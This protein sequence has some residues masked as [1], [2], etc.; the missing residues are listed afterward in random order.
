M[1][2][3]Y[4][5]GGTTSYIRVPSSLLWLSLLIILCC[6]SYTVATDHYNRHTFPTPLN[7]LATSELLSAISHAR[8]YSLNML[9][10]RNISLL[11]RLYIWGLSVI[12]RIAYGPEHRPPREYEHPDAQRI[13][14]INSELEFGPHVWQN[15]FLE[16]SGYVS[17][18]HRQNAF[19]LDDVATFISDGIEAI[20]DDTLT[21]CFTA[22]PPH[23]WN[24]LTRNI[25]PGRWHMTPYNSLLWVVGIWARYFVF[26]PMR[27]VIVILGVFLF[28]VAWGM[29]CAIPSLPIKRHV[30]KWL[31]RFLA[32]VVAASWSGYI[33][34]H[35]KRPERR[36]H[37][38][39][40][41]N[42][43]SLIDLFI[44]NK[45]YNFSCIGQRHAGLAGM[46]QTLLMAAQDH[47]WFDR[48]E[49]GDRRVVT[50]LLREHVADKR[51]EPMLVFPEGTCTNSEYCVMFKKGSFELG[52]D[53]YPIAIKYHKRFGDP[54]WNSQTTSFPRHLFD[55]MTSWA[56]VCDV[57]YLEPQ[58][59]APSETSVQFANR[60]KRLIC[61]KAGLIS[62]NWD[63]FL[64]RHRISPKFLESRQSALASVI[65]RRL[66]GELPRAVSSS[67]LIG[68]NLAYPQTV[69]TVNIVGGGLD[70][71]AYER[72]F[73]FNGRAH[74]AA[75]SRSAKSYREM[76]R[77]R[78]RDREEGSSASKM[79]RRTIRE[80][81]R[82]VLG[83][84]LL[85]AAAVLTD[86][87]MPT[88]MKET[89]RSRLS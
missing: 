85:V 20:V 73:G 32:S 31:L 39:Y 63:G 67:V 41:A 24:F 47:V 34:F 5:A 43:T 27:T 54:F 57:Y 3:Q 22:D 68:M 29:A 80:V 7:Y 83:I 8:R 59:R 25:P 72:P 60:V 6:L 61:E 71:L 38:I 51:K 49:G 50:Q 53:V 87:F 56:V 45:D 19:Q 75:T 52:A 42:H 2:A 23:P 37:Q 10:F 70:T 14:R 36:A 81:L 1:Y 17:S 11:R 78:R 35:G 18:L 13:K 21:R 15:S 55:L 26:L 40:V 88:A 16:S 79:V 12:T 58:S 89:M 82:W 4:Q 69:G 62:V 86:R 65:T 30:R 48:E 84:G 64:K 77:R 44:L 66:K 9:K 76:L 46:L 74:R 28:V 33:K